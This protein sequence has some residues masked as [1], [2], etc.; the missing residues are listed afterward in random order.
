VQNGKYV[1]ALILEEM[2]RYGGGYGE[3]HEMGRNYDPFEKQAVGKR[4]ME[5]T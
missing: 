3:K 4:S 2:K 5:S 1:T